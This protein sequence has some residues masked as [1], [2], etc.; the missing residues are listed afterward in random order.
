MSGVPYKTL[1]L[2]LDRAQDCCERCGVGNPADVHH[3]RA[4]GMGGT[5]DPEIHAAEAL[6]V[7]C[8]DCHHWIE[9]NRAVAE[10]QGWLVPRRDPRHPR[11][12]PVFIGGAW[13]IVTPYRLQPI[14][15]DPGF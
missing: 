2:V 3:R 6:V 8:R 13:Y 4:R 9:T 7:L 15:L 14:S 12:V 5:K 1:R 10:G 11:D